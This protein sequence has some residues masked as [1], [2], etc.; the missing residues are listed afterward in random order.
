MCRLVTGKSVYRRQEI[1]MA[2]R[3][4][5]PLKNWMFGKKPDRNVVEWF[6]KQDV[7]TRVDDTHEQCLF[8]LHRTQYVSAKKKVDHRDALLHR[9]SCPQYQ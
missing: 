8:C 4:M 1:I 6:M 3:Q 5:Q 7:H 9:L 2:D